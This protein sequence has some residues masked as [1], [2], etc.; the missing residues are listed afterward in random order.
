[1]QEFNI[2]AFSEFIKSVQFEI[3]SVDDYILV[4]DE[5]FDTRPKNRSG[6]F[7]SFKSMCHNVDLHKCKY[8]LALNTENMIFT[9]YSSCGSFDLLEL[10]KKRYELIGESH[11]S[12]KCMQLICGICGIPFE[13]N[14]TEEVKVVEYDWKK[15][16]GKYVKGKKVVDNEI[17]VYDDSIL[18]YFPK[19]YHSEWVDEYGIS[20]ETMEKFDIR[21]YPYKNSILLPCY[22][23]LGRLRGIRT[24]V[25]DEIA[26]ENGSP[27]YIPLTTI[28]GT[29]YKFGTGGMLYGEY[30]N[31]EEIRKQKVCY[32]F[33]SEKSNLRLDTLMNGKGVGLS[34]MGSNMSDTN[35]MYILSL[36][37]STV[38]ICPDNDFLEFG[39]DKY[40]EFEKKVM[41]L[42]QRFT[43]FVKVE[44]IFNNIGIKNMY[45]ASPFDFTVEQFK[46][47]YKNRVR[48][49]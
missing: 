22:D 31:E 35:I 33:E 36:E 20:Q 39:D 4:I 43:P 2:S 3:M 49:N 28:D 24:R 40:K 34:M 47:M 45:K 9:C 30:Q 48:L 23:K 38:R 41:K 13:F 8:N 42:A 26:I 1:M 5:L 19:I 46:E 12:Y 14:S 7:I 27:R 44:V 21:W 11:K 6:K 10:V 17:K 37:V 29:T 25:M 18:N 16:M 15:E 32:I